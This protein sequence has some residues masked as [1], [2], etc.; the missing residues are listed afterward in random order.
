MTTQAASYNRFCANHSLTVMLKRSL[1][2]VALGAALFLF[3]GFLAPDSVRAGGL[4][5]IDVAAVTQMLQQ[6][7]QMAQQLETMVQQVGLL[8]QQISSVTGHYGMGAI[9]ARVN[10][11]GATSWTDIATMVGQGVNPG[12]AAQVR[13]FKEAQAGYIVQNPSLSVDLETANPRMNAAYKRAY[14]DGMAGTALGESTFDQVNGYLADVEALK[15]KIDQTDNV[16]AAID[17]NT[18]VCVRVAQLNGEMLRMQAAQLRMQAGNQTESSN[19][20][21][22]QAEFFAQ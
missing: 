19:G 14:S 2:I 10:G 6:S 12:D 22:A 4:P 18:A 7:I 13:A 21:A 16:K 11:W 8:K 1:G 15:G 5:V 3:A 9:G 20:Y 17:L